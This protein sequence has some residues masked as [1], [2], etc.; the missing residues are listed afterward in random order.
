M[1][2]IA[3]MV[4]GYLS[5]AALIVTARLLRKC[6]LCALDV[7]VSWWGQGERGHYIGTQL[8]E[9]GSLRKADHWHE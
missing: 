8:V 3:G 1:T 2:F 7:P 6:P 5:A 9:C 4:V